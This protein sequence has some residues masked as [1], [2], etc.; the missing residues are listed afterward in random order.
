MA[1]RSPKSLKTLKKHLLKTLPKQIATVIADYEEFS[2]LKAPDD[3][4]GFAAH[5]AA[6]K[7]A[8]AHVDLLLKLAKWTEGEN[9][10]ENTENLVDLIAKAKSALDNM[11]E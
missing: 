9:L 8:I 10:Q 1:P 2:S 4:K 6:C 7:T 3:P 11:D 5:H